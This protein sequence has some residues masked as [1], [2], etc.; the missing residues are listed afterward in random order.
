MTI[1][2]AVQAFLIEQ[3]VKGNT[4][5]TRDNYK[6]YLGYFQDYIGKDTNIKEL[7]AGKLNDYSLSLKNGKRS[8]ATVQTYIRHT[9]AFIGWLE[10]E[11]YVENLH[12]KFKLPKATKK[13]IEVLSDEEIEKVFKCFNERCSLG[14][15]NILIIALMMDSGLRKNEIITLDCD[16]IH[17]SQGVIKVKGKGQKERLVPMGVYAKR[18]LV[19]YLNGGRILPD[20]ESNRLIIDK[21]RKPITQ[22]AIKMLFQRLKKKTG[23]KRLKP[24]LM[25]HTFATRYLINGGDIFSLQQILGHTSLEMVRRYMHLA[26]SYTVR[27]FKRHSP[28]DNYYR[29]KQNGFNNE[30]P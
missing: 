6:T 18:Y 13:I 21:D 11:G 22:N 12:S 25:R 3:E 2:K 16:N 27:T 19:K 10:N 4:E 15:R 1:Q 17:I 28:L 20:L 29:N 24:H 14:L 7:D 23:I 9:R 8:Q 5:K 26:S 30:N